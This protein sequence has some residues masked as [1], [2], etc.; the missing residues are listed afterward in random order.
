MLLTPA[1]SR[2][3]GLPLAHSSLRVARWDHAKP[4]A[5][6]AG[7]K[8]MRSTRARP[9]AGVAA[10]IGAFAALLWVP[11]WG[12]S[13]FLTP[14]GLVCVVAGRRSTPRRWLLWLAFGVNVLVLTATVLAWLPP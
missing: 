14:V 12:L 1:P 6:A 2:S 8:R 13:G 9:W 5:T 11:S 7:R 4:P 10:C 3:C